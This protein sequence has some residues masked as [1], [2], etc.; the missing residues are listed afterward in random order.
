MALS[1]ISILL[2]GGF[3]SFAL[4]A[5]S[6]AG[7]SSQ[8]GPARVAVSG[9]VTLDGQPLASGQ[10]RFLPQGEGPAA[11]AII[12]NG[13]YELPESA[14]P[15]PGAQRVEIEALDYYGFAIDDEAA[16]VEHV[17]KKGGRI[18]RNPVPE[19]YNRRSTLTASVTPDG[20]HEF[21]FQ[22]TSRSSHTA[23][24]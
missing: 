3:L 18:P 4:L 13:V 5:A 20:S 21:N 9:R 11:A 19:I 2:R 6:L 23:Q 1:Q 8:E 10:I 22:L 16:Y 17:E 24:R 12:H 7:C 15:V 14:G